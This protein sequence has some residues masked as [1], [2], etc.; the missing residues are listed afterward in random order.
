MLLPGR[1]QRFRLNGGLGND[2]LSGGAYDDV[3][4]GGDG[5]DTLTGNGG[6]DFL[7]GG[8]GADA[9]WGGDGDDILTAGGN[10][11][12][13]FQY[14]YGQNGND[15]YNINIE[16]GSVI[17][18]ASQAET[19]TSGTADRIIFS[20]LNI[21]DI[22]ITY[23]D[24]ADGVH[25]NAININWNDGTNSGQLRVAQEGQFI[26]EFEFA[27]GTIINNF[28][29]GS[30][31]AETLYGT[32]LDD[33]IIGGAGN[34][35]LVAYDGQDILNGGD[36]YDYVHYYTSTTDVTIN[37]QTGVGSA[38]DAE[39]DTYI[40]IEGIIGSNIGND[41]LSGDETANTILG[42]GGDDTLNGGD[43]G[44]ALWGGDG[45][46]TLIAGGNSTGGWDYLYG[47]NGD[48][49]YNISSTD[50]L[51]FI[52]ASSAETASSGTADRVVFTN[53]NAS[54]ITITYYD[55]A[56]GVHGNAININWDDGTNSGQ[57]RV[58][59][60]GQFIEAFE[61]A[62]GTIVNNFI[63]GTDID[64]VLQGAGL[65]DLI[66]GGDGADTI[67]GHTGDDTLVGGSGGDVL[68]GGAGSDA[69]YGGEGIDHAQYY[70][71]TEGVTVNLETGVGSGGEAEGD[72]YDSIEGVMGSNTADDVLTGDDNAN[73]LQGFGG[74]DQLFGGDG[75][76]TLLGQAD[77]DTL[78]GGSGN[79]ALYGG[80]GADIFVFDE[81]FG[82][83]VIYDFENGVDQLSF[84]DNAMIT[85]LTDLT[86]T[87]SGANAVV[88]DGTN[89]VTITNT[90]ISLIETSDF[91]FS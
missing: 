4:S 69:L 32:A 87:Q 74:N 14:L 6:N 90:D 18:G 63:Q 17:I 1:Q 25:G 81:G 83:D 82:S 62:D 89:S 11:T 64:E 68:I 56:D 49:T 80:A 52:G 35:T 53:L 16:D 15:T 21:S 75:N 9:L 41:T 55:Y 58:A 40:N 54:D 2:Q 47:Q 45:D 5:N 65:D 42:Y 60:E 59:Q 91:M 13:G 46:D 24:Y 7:N 30:D 26:E 48:D 27:D 71:S 72:T 57:L 34:D 33:L 84:T 50:G 29:Q 77:D 51:V 23:H 70:Y 31:A 28:V 85:S 8:D 88:S 86:L 38:G 73:T 79:D 78:N 10:G 43:G 39:G 3:L 66:I 12:G 76:D 67:L 44:D 61:F 19:A 36:G 22:T 20:D 37:L